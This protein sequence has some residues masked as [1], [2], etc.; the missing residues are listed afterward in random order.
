MLG[1]ER[2]I[3]NKEIPLTENNV[4][5]GR[6]IKIKRF[7]NMKSLFLIVVPKVNINLSEGVREI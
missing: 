2:M 7:Y 3:K 5:R 1:G 4:G 6:M